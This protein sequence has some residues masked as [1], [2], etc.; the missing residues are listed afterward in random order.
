MKENKIFPV[1]ERSEFRGKFYFL[2]KCR[3]KKFFQPRDFSCFVLLVTQKN[4]DE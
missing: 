2:L 4:E 3:V 1:F